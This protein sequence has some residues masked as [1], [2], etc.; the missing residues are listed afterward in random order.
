MK[1]TDTFYMA[2][3]VFSNENNKLVLSLNRYG[4]STKKMIKNKYVLI[5]AEVF[6]G[7]PS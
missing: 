6:T 2:N 4:A 3:I 5:L 1:F 7:D